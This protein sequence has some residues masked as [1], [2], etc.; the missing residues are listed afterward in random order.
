MSYCYFVC[1]ATKNVNSSSLIMLRKMQMVLSD[2]QNSILLSELFANSV[3]VRIFCF[4]TIR[5]DFAV[6]VPGFKYE[7]CYYLT[8][9][10]G[11]LLYLFKDTGISTRAILSLIG[12]GPQNQV[13]G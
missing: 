5:A 13:A 4:A 2:G 11:S 3:F 8:V 9:S 7:L 10:L 12:S 6:N 1:F